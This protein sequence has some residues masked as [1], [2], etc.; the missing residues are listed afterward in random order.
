MKKKVE[1]P[2]APKAIGPYSQAIKVGD[3]LFTAGQI[4]IDPEKGELVEGLERQTEQALKNLIAIVEEAGGSKDS[5]VKTTIFLAR[6]EDF[7]K[8]N[9]IYQKFFGEPYP[10]RSTVAVKEL[11]KGALIEI[12]AICHLG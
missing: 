10:A 5:I 1:T 12:E 7:P 4:G 8:V 3:W 2:K 6:M 9:E 11:P